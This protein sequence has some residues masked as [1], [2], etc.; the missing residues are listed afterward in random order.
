MNQHQAIGQRSDARNHP[1][2]AR[3]RRRFG[4]RRRFE[5]DQRIGAVHMQR[6][7]PA[8]CP[9][10]DEVVCW[11]YGFGLRSEPWSKVENRG[12]NASDRDHPFHD[13]RGSWKRGQT[14]RM[15]DFRHVILMKSAAKITYE[16][17]QH[18]F[19]HVLRTCG[20]AVGFLLASAA[21]SGRLIVTYG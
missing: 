7:Q 9:R 18:G 16:E 4:N 17:R 20:G 10:E 3:D 5:L 1:L 8:C 6:H 15:H 13:G 19:C 12:K 11:G 2:A 14:H 21:R